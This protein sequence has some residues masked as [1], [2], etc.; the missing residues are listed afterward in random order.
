M[1][2][3]QLD[4]L[5]VATVKNHRE[6]SGLKEHRFITL[7]LWRSEVQNPSQWTKMEVLAGCTLGDPGQNPLP[8]VSQFLEVARMP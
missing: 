6:F 1:L 8:C 7:Q 3:S 4:S 5:P 2:V